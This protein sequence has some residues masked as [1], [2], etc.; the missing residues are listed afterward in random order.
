MLRIALQAGNT[1]SFTETSNVQRPTPNASMRVRLRRTVMKLGLPLLIGLLLGG[2]PRCVAQRKPAEAKKHP[3]PDRFSREEAASIFERFSRINPPADAKAVFRALGDPAWTG[4]AEISH[5]TILGGWIPIQGSM[6]PPGGVYVIR[7]ISGKSRDDAGYRIYVH[8]TAVFPG[9]DQERGGPSPGFCRFLAGDA[10]PE[11][12][13]D[14]YALCY[15]NTRILHVL[16]GSRVMLP[17]MNVE[18]RTLNVPARGGRS[19]ATP[20]GP[21][22]QE[23]APPFHFA[24]ASLGVI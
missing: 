3:T 23:F 13:I 6:S 9:E 12:K 20:N 7:L 4:R 5:Q 16:P 8:V 18:H 10:P 21:G 22:S 15:P 19:S 14:E 17:S 1:E 11:V 24:A 2:A